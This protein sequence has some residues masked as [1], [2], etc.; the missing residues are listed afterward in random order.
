MLLVER[1]RSAWKEL[2]F[3]CVRR[4]ASQKT[5]GT[6]LHLRAVQ[7]SQDELKYHYERIHLFT[8]RSL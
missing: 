1:S 5:T 3:D 2:S 4:S 8:Q 7:V 6:H